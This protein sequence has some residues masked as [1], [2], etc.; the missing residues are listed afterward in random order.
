MKFRTRLLLFLAIMLAALGL[1]LYLVAEHSFR[2]TATLEQQQLLNEHNDYLSTLF[3][4]TSIPFPILFSYAS[5]HQLRITVIALDGAVLFDSEEDP[6]GM[7][8]HIWRE[9]V[10][11]A[12]QEGR[13]FAIRTSATTG[14]PMYYATR[15]LPSS[16]II[17]SAAFSA[18]TSSWEELFLSR[19]LSFL[20][21]FIA[22]TLLF[23]LLLVRQLTKPLSLLV[24]QA[25]GYGEGKLHGNVLFDGPKELETL[26]QTMSLMA[27]RLSTEMEDLETAKSRSA[28]TLETMREG[29][30]LLDKTKR[31]ILENSA[32][33]SFLGKGDTLLSLIHEN[34]VIW[35]V[36]ESL[37]HGTVRQVKMEKAG[38]TFQTVCAPIIMGN[39]TKG[40]VLTI[41]DISEL[42]RL[43]Q[44]RKDFV[45]NV[46]H[47]LKTPLTSLMG[48]SD[49]LSQK[50]LDDQ[51]R[52]H[53]AE[54]LHRSALHMESIISD[55][56]TLASLEKEHFPIPFAPALAEAIVNEAV[57]TTAYKAK[58][59]R[60][61]VVEEQDLPPDFTFPCSANLL[62]QA[63][64]NLLT[65]AI[66]YS[67]EGTLVTLRTRQEGK[68]ILF[69]VQ[70]QG[71]GIAKEEQQRI[72]ERFYR[73]DK[74]RSRKA[75]GTGLGLSIVR[76]IAM[77]HHGT[78]TVESALG[79]GSLFT[80]SLPVEGLIDQ[81]PK[82]K[83]ERFGP[84]SP[85]YC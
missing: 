40:A 10:E 58:E 62:V 78:I 83:D 5:T 30:L 73:V 21:A 77:I 3:N 41:T 59:K 72:F 34:M 57:E 65:N 38:K 24:E 45:A 82:R 48:F 50:D 14:E 17:R 31:V 33:V 13:G 71:C 27:Q 75:G 51:E 52:I 46:S 70:D 11:E 39:E 81:L 8:N 54:V 80:L 7:D 32:A 53:Y 74:A 69:S 28:T 16:L 47:E 2:K 61:S 67:G 60:I 63:L 43:E 18:S 76:H 79:R 20:L 1:A 6:K 36:D 68:R 15:L 35:A 64:S 85:T 4:D 26:S 55:L 22:I 12:K 49:I 66:L 56:L 42:S 23:G 25:K 37:S 44:V 29:V 9:E 84:E 19:Y